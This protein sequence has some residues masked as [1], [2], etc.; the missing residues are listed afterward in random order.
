MHPSTTRPRAARR[1]DGRSRTKGGGPPADTTERWRLERAVIV[2]LRK[3]RA[4]PLDAEPAKT[5]DGRISRREVAPVDSIV[6]A[7]P[8]RFRLDLATADRSSA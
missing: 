2:R 6:R 7:E 5:G 3:R 8:A 4:A 1:A